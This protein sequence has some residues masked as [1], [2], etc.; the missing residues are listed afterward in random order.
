M[1]EEYKK[2]MKRMQNRLELQ[3]Y[4]DYQR[5]QILNKWHVEFTAFTWLAS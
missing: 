4:Y 2:T 3:M 5:A 1:K